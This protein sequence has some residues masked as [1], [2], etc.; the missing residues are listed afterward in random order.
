MIDRFSRLQARYD[1]S[2][3]LKRQLGNVAG[4]ATSL[5]Q[6]GT[7]AEEAGDL[8]KAHELFQEA[9]GTFERLKS[10]HAEVARRSL[11]R[12]REKLDKAPEARG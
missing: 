1:E 3:A 4:T 11:A 10:P 6:L 2:L 5:H 8:A 7:L 12:V 9:L